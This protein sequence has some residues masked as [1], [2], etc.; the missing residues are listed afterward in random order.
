VEYLNYL[1]SVIINYA[2]CAREIKSGIVMAKLEIKTF[3]Q[4]IGLNCKKENRKCY[5]WD[6]ALYGAETW[7]FLKIDQ[8]YVESFEMLCWIKMEK[9]TWTQRV[10]N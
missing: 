1:V 3:E 2:I 4:Q 8:I 6:M 5:I 10:R 9:I 7:T